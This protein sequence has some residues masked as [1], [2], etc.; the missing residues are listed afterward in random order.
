MSVIDIPLTGVGG[1]GSGRL[2]P[3][4]RPD[5]VNAE[6][7]F[8]LVFLTSRT[9]GVT[10]WNWHIPTRLLVMRPVL[11]KRKR[12]RF[13]SVITLRCMLRIRVHD[14]RTIGS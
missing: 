8:Q 12:G 5:L 9:C 11:L 3:Q 14:Y 1:Q 6:M 13:A 4:P 10:E 2:G 7:I